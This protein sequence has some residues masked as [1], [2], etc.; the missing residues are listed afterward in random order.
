MKLLKIYDT[1]DNGQTY[2]GRFLPDKYDL[3]VYNGFFS[4]RLKHFN[5]VN[6]MIYANTYIERLW[7]Q[8]HFLKNEPIG[9][10]SEDI[11]SHSKWQQVLITDRFTQA[12]FISN[13]RKI[14]DECLSLFS[15]AT[16][17][18]NS[19]GMPIESIGEYKGLDKITDFAANASFLSNLNFVSNAFK[20]SILGDSMPRIGRD[21]PCI[22]IIHLREDKKTKQI[23]VDDRGFT[24]EYFVNEFNTFY[25]RF[26]KIIK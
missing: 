14:V 2:N 7:E 1:L 18:Y 4:F 22:F 19:K 16:N 5:V 21:E 20:H 24:L 25:K 13:I 17:Q 9:T 11:T 3:P 23:T 26:D 8:W 12:D 6:R 10:S 15:V